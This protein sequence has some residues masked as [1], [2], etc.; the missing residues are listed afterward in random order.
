MPVRC[1]LL[2]IAKGRSTVFV[3][4]SCLV[5]TELNRAMNLCCRYQQK[6]STLWQ[7][8]RSSSE[9][10]CS[11]VSTHFLFWR[12][13]KRAQSG[14]TEATSW[15][16]PLINW[17]VVKINIKPVSLQPFG[18]MIN[19]CY[20]LE[21]FWK[22]TTQTE[23]VVVATSSTVSCLQQGDLSLDI[24]VPETCLLCL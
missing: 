22:G 14:F 7:E 10:E 18:E 20:F 21:L 1:S 4:S 11:A 12:E 19:L 23:S 6:W 9:N 5:F 16:F 17:S 2:K 8:S 15:Q 3:L 13:S 24:T